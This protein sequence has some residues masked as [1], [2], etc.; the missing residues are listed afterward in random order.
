MS[1][2]K[3]LDIILDNE[4]SFKLHITDVCRRL[5]NDDGLYIQVLVF[6]V[7]DSSIMTLNYS[8]VYSH[9]NQSVVI[10][11]GASESNIKHVRVV[12]NKILRIIF[13]VKHDDHK[14]PEISTHELYRT[15]SACFKT[16]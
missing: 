3:Y 16:P 13:H 6:E 14:I 5:R 2:I 10:R 4:L 15:L 7:G 8:L 11:G 1:Y 9:I 12:V